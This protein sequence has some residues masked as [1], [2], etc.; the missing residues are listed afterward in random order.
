[1]RVGGCLSCGRDY[2]E[3]L[4]RSVWIDPEWNMLTIVRSLAELPKEGAR[5]WLYRMCRIVILI[6]SVADNE[7]KLRRVRVQGATVSGLFGNTL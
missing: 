7:D 5:E 4:V 3:G 6:P 1:M 2:A